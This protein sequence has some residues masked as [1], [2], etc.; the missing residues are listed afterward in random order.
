MRGWLCSI[1]SG[2]TL[3]VN[4]PFLIFCMNALITISPQ[5]YA[6][7]FKHATPLI[8]NAFVV[9]CRLSGVVSGDLS[10]ADDL[11]SLDP[12]KEWQNV[13][14]GLDP[15]RLT[16]YYN[17]CS[18]K[19]LFWKFINRQPQKIEDLHSMQRVQQFMHYLITY[20]LLLSCHH[21]NVTIGCG[22]PCPCT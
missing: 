17:K 3:F 19:S 20:L 13:C 12:D 11:C 14:P 18:W 6:L 9:V 7:N 4:S 22:W 16:L 5:L 21:R 8:F 2:F 10:T 15:N 1:S